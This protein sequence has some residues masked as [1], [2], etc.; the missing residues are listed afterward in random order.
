VAGGRADR[1]GLH[2]GCRP[3]CRFR[4][5]GTDSLS[6]SGMKW[7][8]DERWYKTADSLRKVCTTVP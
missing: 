8:W 5:R 3:R 1:E 2:L 4:N 7:T 6:E